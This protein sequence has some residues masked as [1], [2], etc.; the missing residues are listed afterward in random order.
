MGTLT[1]DAVVTEFDDR[2]LAHLQIVIVNKL[3]R[4]ESLRC[5]GGT[6]RRWTWC[7]LAGSIALAVA[8]RH[9]RFRRAPFAGARHALK[10]EMRREGALEE[11]GSG[12]GG[13]AREDSCR[14]QRDRCSSSS[15]AATT[16]SLSSRIRSSS[17][18]PGTIRWACSLIATRRASSS[19]RFAS[20]VNGGLRELPAAAI[21]SGLERTRAEVL[22]DAGAYRVAIDLDGARPPLDFCAGTARDTNECLARGHR[23]VAA[24]APVVQVPCSFT[25]G[26]VS[27]RAPKGKWLA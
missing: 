2:L 9:V 12:C 1:Y 6:R 22:L 18:C 26:A 17:R 15:I 10:V 5:P 16:P 13:Q 3:G 19:D 21:R 27:A 24:L 14:D 25:P 7:D 20:G 8:M 11:H 4:H 23:R